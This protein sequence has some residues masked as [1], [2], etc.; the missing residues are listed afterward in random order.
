MKYII[1]SKRVR[2]YGSVIIYAQRG[3]LASIMWCKMRIRKAVERSTG[4]LKGLGIKL[5]KGEKV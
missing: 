1:I 5:M 2:Q 4:T 3:V